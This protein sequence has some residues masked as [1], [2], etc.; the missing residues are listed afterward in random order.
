MKMAMDAYNDSS[1]IYSQVRDIANGP[2]RHA[3]GERILPEGL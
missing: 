1:P 3:V 2:R